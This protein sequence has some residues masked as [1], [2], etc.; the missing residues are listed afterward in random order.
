MNV[1]MLLPT[2]IGQP[3]PAVTVSTAFVMIAVIWSLVGLAF[4]VWYLW[5]LSRLFPLIGLP[6]GQGWIPIWNQVLLVS[7]GGFPGWL[8]FLVIIPGVSI[9][10]FVLLMM[11]IHRLHKEFNANVA[12]IWFAIF[13]P[14]VWAMVFASHLEQSQITVGGSGQAGMQGQLPVKATAAPVA[15]PSSPAPVAARAAQVAPAAPAAPAQARPVVQPAPAVPRQ[16]APVQPSAQPAPAPAPLVEPAAQPQ[17]Q[18]PAVPAPVTPAV[19]QEPW[20]V[21]AAEQ[22]PQHE[23]WGFSRTTEDAFHQLAEEGA[24]PGT[25]TPLEPTAPPRPFMWPE[26]D[27]AKPVKPTPVVQ[28]AA[29]APAPAPATPAPQPVPAPA[30]API[31][32]AVQ[33]TAQ[34]TPELQAPAP[35]A[36]AQVVPEPVVP[37]QVPPAPVQEDAPTPAQAPAAQAPAQSPAVWPILPEAVVPPVAPAANRLFATDDDDDDNTIAV[38]RSPRWGLVLGS[39]EVLVIPGDDV[40]VGRK[41]SAT[42]ESVTLIVEDPTR[43]LSKSHVRMIRTGGEWQIVDLN[44]TNGV[45]TQ[46]ASGEWAEVAPGTRTIASERMMFGTLEVRLIPLD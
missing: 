41:P 17:P 23:G 21:P 29:A 2:E 3:D 5:S 43:T 31:P 28:P 26:P 12:Y 45:A 20:E 24:Q 18:S 32:E 13:L 33:P 4:F 30:P 14:P 36:P 46:A 19:A 7:R 34:P 42:A 40:I 11:S 25:A 44:S 39:N 22:D 38:V 16:A 15:R 35:V 37:A 8:M 9:V 27:F 1:P 6:A 10:P